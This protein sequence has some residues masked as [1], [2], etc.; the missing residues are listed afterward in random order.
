[1]RGGGHRREGLRQ[2]RPPRGRRRQAHEGRHAQ[3]VP[4]PP[5]HPHRA[6]QP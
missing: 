6:V 5:R 4:A 3:A 2:R 1:M